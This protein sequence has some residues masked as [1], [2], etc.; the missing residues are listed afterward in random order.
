M[1]KKGMRQGAIVAA[2]FMKTRR[3][4]LSDPQSHF[5]YLEILYLFCTEHMLVSHISLKKVQSLPTPTLKM[6]QENLEIIH[7]IFKS[8]LLNTFHIGD[9]GLSFPNDLLKRQ[10][11]HFC[12]SP[13]GVL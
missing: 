12:L 11:I 4:F 5:R 7:S 13:S 3:V 6:A 10:C 9:R 1:N 8:Y 2:C